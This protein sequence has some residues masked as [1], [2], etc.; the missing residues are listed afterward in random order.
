M[1]KVWH[2]ALSF[3]RITLGSLPVPPA[4]SCMNCTVHLQFINP[5][6]RQVLSSILKTNCK[7]YRVPN[8]RL[9]YAHFYTPYSL[10]FI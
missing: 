4:T 6:L 7:L 10:Q 5:L 8:V 3:S 1:V 9:R 2:K